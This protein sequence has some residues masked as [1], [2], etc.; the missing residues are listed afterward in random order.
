MYETEQKKRIMVNLRLVKVQSQKK[1]VFQ[2]KVDF[3]K[4]IQIYKA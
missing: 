1:F 4:L 2:L 3:K